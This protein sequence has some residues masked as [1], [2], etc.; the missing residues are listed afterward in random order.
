LALVVDDDPVGFLLLW[1]SRRDPDEPADELFVWRILVDARHQRQG[2]GEQAMRWVIEEA[3][4]LGVAR[5]GL[6]HV[7]ASPVGAFYQRLGFAYTGA[8][9]DGERM[10]VL[11][12]SAGEPLK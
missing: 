7:E 11:N 5:V 10:M 12:L 2:Y 4:R 8:V 9:V 1:D 3:R 6:S